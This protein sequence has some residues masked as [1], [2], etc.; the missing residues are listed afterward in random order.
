MTRMAGATTATVPAE[1]GFE[2][3]RQHDRRD[4]VLLRQ[5]QVHRVAGALGTRQWKA[6][7]RLG[8]ERREAQDEPGSGRDPEREDQAEQSGGPDEGEVD[9]AVQQ[10]GRRRAVCPG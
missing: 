5:R 4:A 3:Q 8:A 9:G 7:H 10:A 6:D 2:E 1:R